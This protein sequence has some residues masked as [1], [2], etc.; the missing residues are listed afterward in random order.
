MKRIIAVVTSAC[1][2]SIAG[3]AAAQT[4]VQMDDAARTANSRAAVK[5]LAEDL[6]AR[7][8]EALKTGGPVA[9]IAACNKAAQ[10]ATADISKAQGLTIKRTALRVRNPLNAASP[11][12]QVVLRS[13]AEKIKAGADVAALEHT[14]TVKEGDAETFVYMKAIP[15][16]GD[17]CQACHGTEVKPEVKA[18]IGKL[19]PKDEATGFTPGELRGAFVVT[20]K[21]K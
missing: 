4:S 8:V 15:M 2:V 14:E 6:K 1:I 19:Y 17:P 3:T 9:G 13:F 11:R 7:L 5:A 18:E 16:A 20:Q 10:P 12:E 21:I